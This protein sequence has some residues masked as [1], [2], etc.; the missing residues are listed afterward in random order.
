MRAH[1]THDTN[2]HTGRWTEEEERQRQRELQEKEDRDLQYALEVS[3]YVG[4]LYLAW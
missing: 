3:K 1:N 2:T 4:P